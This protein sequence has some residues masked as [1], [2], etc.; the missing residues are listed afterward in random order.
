[1]MSLIDVIDSLDDL[2]KYL[3]V[4][5][6]ASVGESYEAT[7]SDGSMSLIL[8]NCWEMACKLYFALTALN[9]EQKKAKA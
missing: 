6:A 3:D 2:A 5:H 8:A 1:M 7:M 9:D 4:A